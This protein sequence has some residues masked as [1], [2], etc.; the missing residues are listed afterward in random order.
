[1]IDDEV[2]K[3]FYM[4][5]VG[6]LGGAVR[7]CSSH[8]MDNA[9]LIISSLM[10]SFFASGLTA[11]FMH[12]YVTDQIMLGGLCGLG[13]YFGQITLVIIAKQVSK[14]TGIPLNIGGNEP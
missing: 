13:G 6:L 7:V 11:A 10:V 2:K 1:V 5:I 8:R 4:A 12:H 14:R 3:V 9:R